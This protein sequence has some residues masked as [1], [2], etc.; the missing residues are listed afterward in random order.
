MLS[1]EERS[2]IIGLLAH[3]REA[4]TCTLSMLAYNPAIGRVLEKGGVRRFSELMV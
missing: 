1:T 2:K 3:E 4:I